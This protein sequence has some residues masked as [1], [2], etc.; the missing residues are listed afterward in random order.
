MLYYNRQ[1]ITFTNT[2]PNPEEVTKFIQY[3][4]VLGA[5]HRGE[6]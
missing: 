2:P 6:I 3:V 5:R 1:F 4:M